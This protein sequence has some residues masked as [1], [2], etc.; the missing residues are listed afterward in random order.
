M[1]SGWGGHGSLGA[2][3]SHV[4]PFSS[5]AW[6]RGPPDIGQGGRG[7]RDPSQAACTGSAPSCPGLGQLVFSTV[8]S[9]DVSEGLPRHEA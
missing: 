3:L 5:G 7:G 2:G 6:G 4:V 9:G 1:P 8:P